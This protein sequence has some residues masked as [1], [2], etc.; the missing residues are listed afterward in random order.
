M[1]VTLRRFCACQPQLH[2]IEPGQHLGISGKPLPHGSGILGKDP[3]CGPYDHF[4]GTQPQFPLH[5]GKQRH[6]QRH[7]RD[8]DQQVE[9]IGARSDP[10]EQAKYQR[11]SAQRREHLT[12]RIAQG[13]TASSP[14]SPSSRLASI[15]R[16][17]APAPE[18]ISLTT[19]ST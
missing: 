15:S 11:R 7:Q 1:T 12:G 17:S 19:A 10:G 4:A 13:G 16:E 5:T 2:G 14:A 8:G 18:A 9:D 6:G 3:R